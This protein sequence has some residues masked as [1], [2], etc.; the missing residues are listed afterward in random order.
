MAIDLLSQAEHSE[1]AQSILIVD[2]KAYGECVEAE[3]ERYLR[4]LPRAEIA[5]RSWQHFGAIIVV[6]DLR[7]VGKIVDQIAPEHVE[8]AMGEPEK[9]AEQIQ[10]AGAIF[11]GRYTPE[12]IGD[13]VAGPSHVLPTNRTA[14]FSSGLSVYDFLN[15]QS[16]IATTRTG[17]QRMGRAGVSIARAEGLEAHA[18]SMACRLT[19]ESGGA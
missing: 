6:D 19:Q 14:R 12:A 15:K 7:N 9:L 13:Y 17:I 16:V 8:L 5:A 3:V 18:L 10:C 11:M 4:T 1:D 2:D